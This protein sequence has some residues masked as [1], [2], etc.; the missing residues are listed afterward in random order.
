MENERQ[1]KYNM[2]YAQWKPATGVTQAPHV[3]IAIVIS[4]FK[5]LT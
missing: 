2:Q 1:T 4:H 3:H 5:R